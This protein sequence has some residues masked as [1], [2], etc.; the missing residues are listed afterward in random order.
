MLHNIT[1]A[2]MSERPVLRELPRCGGHS[3]EE[4]D[5]GSICHRRAG[6][7]THGVHLMRCRAGKAARSHCH[8]NA[9]TAE[10]Q[11]GEEPRC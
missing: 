7:I 9:F 10:H 6:L 1:V 3:G 8:G 2:A 4:R 5:S 11:V